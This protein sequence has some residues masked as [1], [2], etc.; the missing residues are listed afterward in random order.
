[1]CDKNNFFLKQS[2]KETRSYAPSFNL[3]RANQRRANLRRASG[4]SYIFIFQNVIWRAS[5]GFCS[6]GQYGHFNLCPTD[7]LLRASLDMTWPQVSLIGGLLSV[8]CCFKIGQANMEWYLAL[9]PTSISIGS[10]SLAFQTPATCLC[11]ITWNSW[12]KQK[13]FSNSVSF[14]L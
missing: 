4:D 13:S 3:R 5:L 2:L 7:N 11:C 8:V 9:G 6:C 1:M 14:E 10:S 12:I